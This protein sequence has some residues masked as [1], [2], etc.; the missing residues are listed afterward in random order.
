[1]TGLSGSSIPVGGMGAS[2]GRMARQHEPSSRDDSEKLA[3][4]LEE[5]MEEFKMIDWS[6][7][8]ESGEPSIDR[9][10]H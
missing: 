4:F 1:M 2:Y 5:L 9:R 7:T 3:Q 10:V 6:K 8:K